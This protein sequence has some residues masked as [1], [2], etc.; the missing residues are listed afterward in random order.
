[1]R[2]PSFTLAV[3]IE[4][5]SG[6]ALRIPA[7]DIPE[8]NIW[9]DNGGRVSAFLFRSYGELGICFPKFAAYIFPEAR[10]Q[11]QIQIVIAPGPTT[12][13]EQVID[14]FVRNVIP[15][16]LQSRGILVLHASAVQVRNGVLGLG[17]T[18]FSGKSTLACALGTRGYELWADDSL[19]ILTT[20]EDV[21]ALKTPLV[22]LRLRPDARRYFG[23][24]DCV[25]LPGAINSGGEFELS[26]SEM[27]GLPLK[28]LCLIHRTQ[29]KERVGLWHHDKLH[30]HEALGRVLSLANYYDLA[31]LSECRRISESCLKLVNKVPIYNCSYRDGFESIED[32]LDEMENSFSLFA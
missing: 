8:V 18:S 7:D 3:R 23:K 30:G 13:R 20:N 5:P 19:L 15:L 12:T 26:L 1:V 25:Y 16:L 21:Q 17:G 2:H 22:K 10:G 14:H 29:D 9:R 24:M 28:A 11:E 31:E 27:H 6:R 4:P 32:V